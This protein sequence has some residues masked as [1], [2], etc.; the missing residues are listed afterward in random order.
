MHAAALDEPL[1]P[2]EAVLVRGCVQAHR[3]E[4]L[5]DLQQA[6]ALRVVHAPHLLYHVAGHFVRRFAA[7]ET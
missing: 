7:L 2:L 4:E 3:I 1:H 5:F 6:R